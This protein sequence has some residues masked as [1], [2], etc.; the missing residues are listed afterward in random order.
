MYQGSGRA[1]LGREGATPTPPS[2]RQENRGNRQRLKALHRGVTSGRSTSMCMLA[3][4]DT[5]ARVDVGWDL[6]AHVTDVMRCA[7][8]WCCP[9]CT[10][11]I[12]EGRAVEIDEGLTGH[13]AAGGGGEFVTFTVRHHLRDALADRL[14][15][16][17]TAFRWV[18]KGSGWDRRRAR[19]GYVGL[20]RAVEVNWSAA[21]GWHPHVHAVLLFDRPLTECERADL[22]D[23]LFG[24][25]SKRC[26]DRGFGEVTQ[27]HGIDVRPM[28]VARIGEYIAKVE[29]DWSAGRELARGDRKPAGAF[30]LLRAFG[31]TGE[32]KWLALW[33]EYEAA[34]RGRRAI[35]W[36]PGLRGRLRVEELSDGDLVTVE[37]ATVAVW[38]YVLWWREWNQLARAGELGELLS[39]IEAVCAAFK[40]GAAVCGHRE[41]LGLDDPRQEAQKEIHA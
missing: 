20:I 14:D 8:P 27:E 24:R 37:A 11:V 18:L 4:R 13:L 34:T 29:G 31:E 6:I 26:R 21:N 38:R 28:T 35:Q 15:A 36:T 16:V 39:T 33:S 12:R 25:W 41:P 1:A 23:W 40:F 3:V 32:S 22:R 2:E 19:L 30:A 10:P 9:I 5:F 7:S 17:L